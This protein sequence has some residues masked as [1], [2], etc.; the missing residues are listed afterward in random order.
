MFK[1]ELFLAL[2]NVT[3]IRPFWKT[4]IPNVKIILEYLSW[5]LLIHRTTS[6]K[7]HDN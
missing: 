1:A 6:F 4:D 5:L 7:S 2:H 3:L